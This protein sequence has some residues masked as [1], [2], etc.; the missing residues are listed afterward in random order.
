VWE[1]DSELESNSR[2]RNFGFSVGLRDSWGGDEDRLEGGIRE[3]INDR[4]AG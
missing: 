3:G 4:S 1:E 2:K